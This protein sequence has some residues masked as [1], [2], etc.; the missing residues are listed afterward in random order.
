FKDFDTAARGYID[1]AALTKMGAGLHKEA[2]TLIKELGLDGLQSIR[3][4]SGFEGEAERSLTEIDLSG[5]RKGVLSLLGGKPFTFHD[6]PPLP[7]DVISWSMATF[8]FGNAYDVVLK[9]IETV[10]KLASPD[11]VGKVR[12]FAK[13]ADGAIG[14]D[15]RKDLL[16]ALGDRMVSYNSPAE[17]V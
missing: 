4:Y 10:V 3:F 5:G 6:A 1:I 12:G 11:D 9:S 16:G 8:D 2:A 15:I 14:V 13:I 17:G 7:P